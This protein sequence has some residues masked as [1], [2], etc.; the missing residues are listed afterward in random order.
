M[1]IKH[2]DNFPF[3]L[4]PITVKNLKKETITKAL[5]RTIKS[6]DNSMPTLLTTNGKLKCSNVLGC[7]VTAESC[8]NLVQN[9]EPH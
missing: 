8:K 7:S 6:A 1:V 4:E 5:H 2:R 9:L 3:I